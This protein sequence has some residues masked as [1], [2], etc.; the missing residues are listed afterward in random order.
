[1]AEQKEDDQHEHTFSKYVRIRDVAQKT[2]QRRWTIRKSGE[3]GSGISVLPARHDDDDDDDDLI[4]IIFKQIYL[5][6][7]R[8]LDRY[9]HPGR[10]CRIHQRVKTRLPQRVSW[11]D[12]KQSDG[13]VTEMLGLWGMRNQSLPSLPGPLWPG[14]VAP[15]KV[16][17]MGQ[18]ELKC[19]LMLNRIVWNRTVL[20]FT[21]CKQNNCTWAKLNCL[22]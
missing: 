10:G 8:Y 9:D 15:D 13:V 1:M 14:V 18:K 11:Y 5:T 12:T 17:S 20:H 4:Q 3:S 21:V 7:R 22:K 19:V 2:C 6:Y 16:L